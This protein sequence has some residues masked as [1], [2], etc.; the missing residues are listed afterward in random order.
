METSGLPTNAEPPFLSTITE[1]GTSATD[2]LLPSCSALPVS[3]EL[4]TF[5][6]QC[7]IIY[8]AGQG[9]SLRLQMYFRTFL[10][11]FIN[12]KNVKSPKN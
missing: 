10:M 5:Q 2:H 12:C 6:K 1:D 11:I 3:F 4:S 9:P 7:D 8:Q